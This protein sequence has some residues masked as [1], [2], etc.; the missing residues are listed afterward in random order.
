MKR[1]PYCDVPMDH[2]RRKQC[3]ALPCKRKAKADYM[4]GWQRR[5]RDGEGRWWNSGNRRP[6][7]ESVCHGCQVVWSSTKPDAKYCS[8]SCQAKHQH[9]EARKRK[10]S[11]SERRWMSAQRS[12]S[13]AAEGT[14]GR[15]PWVTGTCSEC[16]DP[17]ST[18]LPLARTCSAFCAR[19]RE[20]RRYGQY[21]DDRTR[22]SIYE[23]DGWICQLCFD[24]VDPDLHYLDNWAATLDHIVCQ[25]WTESPDHS[26]S[27]LRLAHRWCNSVR[28]NEEHYTAE[29][30][31]A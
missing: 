20:R 10:L 21:V 28:G 6:K 24:P 22:A 12:V 16:G 26:P 5:H 3:G 11:R 27:N 15:T 13:R 17:F 2:P 7:Y 4:R 25:S 1:C 19:S 8:P 29:D 23:R 30:L 14:Q 18:P 31:A 9:G